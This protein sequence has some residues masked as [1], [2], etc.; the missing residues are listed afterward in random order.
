MASVPDLM[1]EA[2]AEQ[3]L[4]AAQLKALK[5]ESA[6]GAVLFGCVW[7]RGVLVSWGGGKFVWCFGVL[8]WCLWG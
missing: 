5:G 4:I 7:E 3:A 8:F 2:R 6:Q 1:A